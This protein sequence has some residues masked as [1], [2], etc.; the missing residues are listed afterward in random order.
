MFI[1]YFSSISYATNA[2]HC[3]LLIYPTPGSFYRETLPLQHTWR[4]RPKSNVEN[5]T[6]KSTEVLLDFAGRAKLVDFGCCKKDES[7]IGV[8]RFGM[9]RDPTGILSEGGLLYV[10]FDVY[11]LLCFWRCFVFFGFKGSEEDGEWRKG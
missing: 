4:K 7:F 3:F 1:P 9:E 6:S 10:F 5:K 11:V 8:H 2:S